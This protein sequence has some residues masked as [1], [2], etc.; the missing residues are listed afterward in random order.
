[1]PNYARLLNYG[2]TMDKLLE[3]DD[4]ISNVDGIEASHVKSED[5]RREGSPYVRVRS[6]EQSSHQT[7]VVVSLRDLVSRFGNIGEYAFMTCIGS[8]YYSIL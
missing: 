2:Y 4:E 8:I 3:D 5:Q 1:M 7:L 6:P